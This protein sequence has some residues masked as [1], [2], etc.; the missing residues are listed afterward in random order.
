MQ[1]SAINT[2]DLNVDPDTKLLLE[3]L[4]MP[5]ASSVKVTVPQRQETTF[6]RGPRRDRA[7]REPREAPA[8]PA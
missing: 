3:K 8:A 6:N 5:F 7:P 2:E 1:V 4:E